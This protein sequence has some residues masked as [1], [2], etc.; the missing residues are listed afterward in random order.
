MKFDIISDLH[1]DFHI[2]PNA[3]ENKMF[4][5]CKNKMFDEGHKHGEILIVAGDLSHYNSQTKAFFEFLV[6]YFYKE[7]FFVTGNH[8]MYLINMN[9]EKKYGNSDAR[10]I[11]LKEMFKDNDKIHMLDGDIVEYKGIKIGGAMG[12]Y[13]GSYCNKVNAF[14]NPLTLW[15]RYS[16]DS[17]LI[18]GYTDFY[19]V[20]MVERPKLQNIHKGCDII[21]S[22]INPM[23]HASFTPEEF[24]QDEGT[25]FYNFD[26][27]QMVDD[28][29]A[30]FWV[31]G[32]QHFTLEKEVYSTTMLCNAL[33]YPKENELA[34][35]KQ[36]EF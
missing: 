33:G 32:H 28:T 16:N 26:G 35:V 19:D 5:F 14:C 22:H 27:E 4:T 36:Y 30:K 8:D 1:L 11:E 24:V 3:N 31:F 17:V 34:R 9:Q 21:V 20:L 12:W 13:D 25:G 15:K 23:P 6:K 7:L 10:L 29:P 2:K 18:K